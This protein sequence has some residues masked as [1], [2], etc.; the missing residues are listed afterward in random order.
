MPVEKP[1]KESNQMLD[2]KKSIIYFCSF[3]IL[4]SFIVSCFMVVL[5]GVLVQTVDKLPALSKE[6][7]KI[8][9]TKAPTV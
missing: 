5:G 1:P 7:V 8:V 4:L 6:D 9:T 3:Y 2:F